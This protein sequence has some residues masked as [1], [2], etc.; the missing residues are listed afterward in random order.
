[1]ESGNPHGAME[2]E[3]GSETTVIEGGEVWIDGSFRREDLVV[4]GSYIAAV[5]ANE[6]DLTTAKRID[7][8]GMLVIPGFCNAHTHTHNVLARGL[9]DTGRLEQLINIQP[10]ASKN[11]SAE[12]TYW[13][14]SLNALSNVKSGVTSVCEQFFSLPEVSLDH[15]DAV[16]RAYSDI[17][18]R[19][20]VAPLLAD[21][22]LWPLLPGLLG[23]LPQELKSAV[24]RRSP[25]K[26]SL[27]T[28]EE[29]VRRWHGSESRRV[30]VAV[31]PSIPLLCSDQLLEGCADI[32]ARFEVNEYI[33]VSESHVQAALSFQQY[34]HGIVEHLARIGTLSERSVLA[35]C[36]WL[37]DREIELVAEARAVVVHNPSS[38]MRLGSGTARVQRILDA[39]ATVALGTDGVACS[40]HQSIFEVMRLAAIASRIRTVDQ[41]KWLSAADVFPLATSSAFRAISPTGPI[42]GAIAVGA[43]ADL[44]LIRRDVP[45]LHPDNDRIV[46]LV[47][48]GSE[49]S[50]DTVLVDGEVVLSGGRATKVDE[51]RIYDEVDVAAS[52][53]RARN[54]EEWL[55][56]DALAPY[57]ADACRRVAP[58]DTPAWT[59]L[60]D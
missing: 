56:T 13:A 16:V 49:A 36:V 24:D 18:L 4:R 31:S 46:Q 40:D 45:F 53:L 25:A 50:V 44:T 29:S 2:L 38:N 23:S 37:T 26:V 15:V 9:F 20:T 33:H 41:T 5:G 7:A 1:M 55:I 58:S 60:A 10:P 30:S 48:A 43:K 51:A 6:T 34:G 35:H 39:G 11:R 12:D 8:S 21:R 3:T 22:P 52:R 54:E 59:E 42:V 57:I 28:V 14:A 27:E 47:L 32:A 19:A 17:G